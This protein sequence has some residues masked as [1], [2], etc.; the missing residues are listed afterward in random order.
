MQLYGAALSPYVM[1]CLLVAR[2]KGTDLPAL[3]FAGGIKSPAYLALNPMGKMPVLVDGDVVLAESAVIA[4]YLNEVLPGHDLAGATPAAR[5]KVR[6]IARVADLYLSEHLG[7]LFQALQK[8]DDA[9]A[10]MA[11]LATGMG[12]LEALFDADALGVAAGPAGAD[13]QGDGITLASA[14]LIPLLFF[15]DA[16]DRQ[17]HSAALIADRPKLAAWWAMAKARPLVA[18]ALAEQAAGLKKMMAAR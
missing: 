1:R 9:P 7:A 17:L 10:A 4:E 6:L 18:A 2:A 13:A 15:F 14:C 11:K 3:D 12:Y 16:F 8:P 5:G